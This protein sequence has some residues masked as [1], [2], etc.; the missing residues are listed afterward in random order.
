MNVNAILSYSDMEIKMDM[1]NAMMGAGL[2]LYMLVFLLAI[3][4]FIIVWWKIFNK[5]GEPGWAILVPFY[6]A[7][8]QFKI[9][10]GNGLFFL[11]LLVP[12]ANVAIALMF[13]FKL[14]K[15]FGK[16]VGFGFGLWL[17]PIV[18]LPILAF[19]SAEFEG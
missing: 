9:A 7:Y 12:L 4:F 13:P 19:G 3:V 8:E 17:L 16:G 10:F 15:A 2:I 14:A 1:K 5:A 6:S 18:F 11:F